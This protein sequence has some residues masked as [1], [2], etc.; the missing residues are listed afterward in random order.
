MRTYEPVFKA[1]IL[2]VEDERDIVRRLQHIL[3]GEGY[4]IVSAPSHERAIECLRTSHVDLAVI[5]LD[6]PNLQGHRL[7]TDI[8]ADAPTES[9]P[10]VTMTAHPIRLQDAQAAQTSGLQEYLFK[11]F[12]AETLLHNVAR[13]LS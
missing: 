13:L 7:A 3:E 1:V 5:D 8:R 11:P 10:I 12:M 2:V 9:L 4:E 6:L